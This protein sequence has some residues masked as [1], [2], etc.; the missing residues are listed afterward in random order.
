MCN[1]SPAANFRVSARLIGAG[2][3]AGPRVRNGSSSVRRV[4]IGRAA[5]AVRAVCPD[6]TCVGAGVSSSTSR[7]VIGAPSDPGVEVASGSTRVA[8]E[9]ALKVIPLPVPAEQL[10]SAL[11]SDVVEIPDAI[12]HAVNLRP[13]LLGRA[14]SGVIGPLGVLSGMVFASSTRAP[15]SARVKRFESMGWSRMSRLLRELP[16]GAAGAES[17][18][19]KAPDRF[20]ARRQNGGVWK[21]ARFRAGASGRSQSRLGRHFVSAS[22]SIWWYGVPGG[23]R[24][25]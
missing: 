23:G 11:R 5:C 9:T 25:A 13:E 21:F 1:G 2:P 8:L 7:P 4:V 12:T 22:A 24:T 17:V 6:W 15:Y 10:D 18:R 20:G 19:R 16:P 14:S 3:A